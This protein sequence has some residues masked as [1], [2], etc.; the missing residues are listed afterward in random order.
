VFYGW[1]IVAAG[2][3]LNVLAGG[4]YHSG[5]SV[6]FL[7]VTRDFGLNRAATSLA[8]GLARLVGGIGGPPL[9]Y[10]ADRLG[11]RT[12]VAFGGVMAG[13]GFILLALTHNFN[14]FLLVYV[15]VLSVGVNAGFNH[16]IMAAVNQ[17]FIRGSGLAMSI[18]TLSI[19]VGG[20]VVTPAIAFIVL[21]WGWRPAAVISGAVIIAAVVP[22]SIVIRRSPES[23]GLLP[24]GDR[25]PRSAHQSR[26]VTQSSQFGRYYTTADFTAREAFRTK[27]YWLLAAATGLRVAA[28]TGVFV[29]LVPLMVWKGQSEA[30]GVFV[31]SFVAFTSIPLRVLLGW[32]GDKWAK[33]KIV[34]ITVSLGA[35]SL[36]MLLQSGGELWQLLIF[37]ALFAFSEGVD[38]L[39]WSLVGDFFGRKSFA[40]IRGGV[41]AVAGFMSMGMPV[42]AGWVYDTSGSYYSALI[43]MIG[44]YLMSA[45]LFWQLPRPRPP[46]RVAD[47]ATGDAS[48]GQRDSPFATGRFDPAC[49]Q[50]GPTAP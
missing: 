24:D 35:A 31:V 22:L 3:V 30:T 33:Q 42:F 19:A 49:S 21:H 25:G 20:A 2:G 10:L 15:A 34:G 43:P 47:P 18:V 11:P 38:G 29:H 50:P 45:L 14:A 8:Y 1:W 23:M 6:Y 41:G 46:S 13:L 48:T 40:T 17:W 12:V 44:M 28:P 4:T 27:T 26:S 37:A 5:L 9:G 36:A 7:P 39:S 32:L 16:G